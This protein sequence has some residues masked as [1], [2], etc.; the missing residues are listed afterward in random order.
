M[1]AA[2]A[3]VCVLLYSANA[4]LNAANGHLGIAALWAAGAVVWL[5]T[6]AMGADS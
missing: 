1:S 5:V 6:L 2:L 4:A 3:V